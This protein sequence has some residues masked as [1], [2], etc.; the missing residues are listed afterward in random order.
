[1]S[2]GKCKLDFSCLVLYWFQFDLV[3]VCFADCRLNLEL[4]VGANGCVVFVL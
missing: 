1:M 2:N 3:V 4:F